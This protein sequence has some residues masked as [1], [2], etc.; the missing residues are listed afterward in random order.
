MSDDKD[1]R[2]RIDLQRPVDLDGL[3]NRARN[4]A[5]ESMR[6]SALSD[7]IVL[8][9]DRST[10]FAYAPSEN[11]V[12]DARDAIQSAIGAQRTAT[13]RVSHWEPSRGK[14]HQTDPPLTYQQEDE[15]AAAASAS[16]DTAQPPGEAAE[17]RP[18]VCVIGKLIRK[19]FEEQMVAFAQALQ[20]KCEIIEHPHLLSTQVVF[21]VTGPAGAVDEF[22][23]YLKSEARFSSR[24]DP[25]LVP[26]GLP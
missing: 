11:T 22:A 4:G 3:V 1:W 6:G 15:M 18:V 21:K 5:G 24:L 10:I 8:S 26:F 14:W 19:S 23:T 13:V 2:L 17:T 7:E 25:G 12:R 20:L 16:D 9:H